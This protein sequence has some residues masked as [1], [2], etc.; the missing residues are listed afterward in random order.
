MGSEMCIRDSPLVREALLLALAVAVAFRIC[1]VALDHAA[2]TQLA[3]DNT[4]GLPRRRALREALA[5]NILGQR[6]E[7]RITSISIVNVV[8]RARRIFIFRE[9]MDVVP[10]FNNVQRGRAYFSLRAAVVRR[11]D[12]QPPVAPPSIPFDKI[13][14]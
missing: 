5:T 4:T 3:L 9:D 8:V 12:A 11:L 1:F 14:R 6:E 2:H 13:T 10:T 7:V